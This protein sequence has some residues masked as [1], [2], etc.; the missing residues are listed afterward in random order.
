MT[1][2]AFGKPLQI[3]KFNTNKYIID[4]AVLDRIFNHA[5]VK[6][7]KIVIFSIMGEFRKGKSFFMDYCLRFM[8]ATYKSVGYMT[9][10]VS[11]PSGWLGESAAGLKGFTVKTPYRNG[12]FGL[13]MWSDVFLYDK[14]DG[15]KIAIVLMKT[16]G[17][18]DNE[19]TNAENS[20]IFALGT[21]LSS[22]Q[23]FNVFSKLT[24][25]ELACLEF[26]TEHAQFG[27]TSFQK[28]MFLIRDWNSTDL[29]DFGP[30]GGENYTNE[31]LKVQPA[32]KTA[33]K[34]IRRFIR[35]SFSKVECVLMPYP[36]KDVARSRKYEGNWAL[37]DEDFLAAFSK[38]IPTL[39]NPEFLVVKK[40]NGIDMTSKTFNQLLQSPDETIDVMSVDEYLLSVVEN[41]TKMHNEKITLTS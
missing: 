22:I 33:L 23:V 30:V 4:Q 38:V 18:F 28:L 6:D 34:S 15:E 5:D 35:S 24:D 27:G 10:Q 37:M 41:Y 2:H 40:I 14:P 9:N 11:D 26:A 7:R 19:T 36:G 17:L 29:F 39:L 1:D 16:D 3:L 8:Y 12:G 21:L 32:Q 13:T 31:F 25:N 20:K